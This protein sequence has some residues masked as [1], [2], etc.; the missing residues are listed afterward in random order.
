MIQLLPFNFDGVYYRLDYAIKSKSKFLVRLLKGNL[1]YKLI[2][3]HIWPTNQNI[4]S[5]S[6]LIKKLDFFIQYVM[7]L[8]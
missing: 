3:L 7:Q 4:L 5:A 6:Y 2:N 8:I 1:V